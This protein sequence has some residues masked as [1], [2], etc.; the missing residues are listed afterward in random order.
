MSKINFFSCRTFNKYNIF[1]IIIVEFVFLTYQS[2][3]WYRA[4][5]FIQTTRYSNE[6]LSQKKKRK[7]R[8]ILPVIFVIFVWIFLLMSFVL[9]LM[10]IRR[11]NSIDLL[12][13]MEIFFIIYGFVFTH[14][15]WN[16]LRNRI[17]WREFSNDY[18]MILFVR[19]FHKKSDVDHK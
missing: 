10:T 8:W 14:T 9:I 5:F 12:S 2:K 4:T 1:F 16:N 17:S 7:K 11:L 13:S 6:T 19:F 15:T 3:R 18:E